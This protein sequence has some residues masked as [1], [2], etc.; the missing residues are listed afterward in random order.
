MAR[1]WGAGIKQSG[2]ILHRRRFRAAGGSV[3][4]ATIGLSGVPT[5]P[6]ALLS[7]RP[8]DYEWSA[9]ATAQLGLKHHVAEDLEGLSW[10]QQAQEK[11]RLDEFVQ[12]APGTAGPQVGRPD[13]PLRRLRR[14]RRAR[15]RHPHPEDLHRLLGNL[16]TRLP[17]VLRSG[18]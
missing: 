10:C 18:G 8:A 13:L 15:T 3:R 11:I 1:I 16:R 17:P 5:H 12:P 2:T 7:A 14:D 6:L 9:V 4:R